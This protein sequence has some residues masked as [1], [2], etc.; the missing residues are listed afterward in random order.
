M[1]TLDLPQ[2]IRQSYEELPYPGIKSQRLRPVWQIAPLEWIRAMCPPSEKGIQRILVA[3]CGTGNE[4]FA[5]RKRMPQAEIVAVDFS[6]RSIELA[7][8]LGRRFAGDHRIE[9]RCVDLTAPDLEGTLGG[10]FDFICCHGVLSY[11]PKPETALQNLARLLA[12]DGGLY[13]GVNGIPHYSELWRPVLREFGFN[14]E[15]F[16][17]GKR[18]REVLKLCDALAGYTGAPIA[19]EAPEYL[20]SDLFGAM[21]ASHPLGQWAALAKRCGLHVCGS[22]QAHR[23]LRAAFNSGFYH[24][25]LPRSR[26]EA[27]LIAEQI[28]PSSFHMLV[29]S[30]A[31]PARVPWK[32]QAQ[33]LSC[34]VNLTKL[35]T[36]DSCK[37]TRTR[38]RLTHLHLRS[39][40]TNTVVDLRVPTWVPLFLRETNSGRPVREILGPRSAR[41]SASS[42]QKHLYLLE[43]LA[44]INLS[45]REPSRS[46]APNAFRRKVPA[47]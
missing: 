4:A 34:R 23:T 29:F 31:A 33:L 22:Y 43:L 25:L 12:A 36:V 16:T 19:T 37:P 21:I 40:P 11:I 18:L 38:S 27:H 13:L 39:E 8:E 1:P 26:A 5:I 3:G 10:K 14:P 44:V 6:G 35:Y 28:V 30:L 17:D 20:A 24:Y 7:R 46:G 45:A 32:N 15:S 2:R 42:L 9:F 41:I 47:L